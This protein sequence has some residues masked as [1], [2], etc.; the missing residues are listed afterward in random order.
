MKKLVLTILVA[1]L[2]TTT[3]INAKADVAAMP[4]GDQTAEFAAG[5]FDLK[6][7]K[8]DNLVYKI[9]EL[10][11]NLNH[12]LDSTTVV[13]VG[14]YAVGG[15]AGFDEAFQITPVGNYSVLIGTPEVVGKTIKLTLGDLEGKKYVVYYKYDRASKKL[16][17]VK[18]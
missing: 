15:A 3:A 17:E 11:S 16:I 8:V 6:I 1:A 10:D 5:I 2:T 9:V 14:E 13:I 12:D 4:Y 7:L 18:K